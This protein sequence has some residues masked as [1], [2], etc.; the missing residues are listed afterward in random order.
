[1][2]LP[3]ASLTPMWI[4]RV[5]LN[6]SSSTR[7]DSVTPPTDALVPCDK[8]PTATAQ[9]GEV[10]YTCPDGWAKEGMVCKKTLKQ[11][12]YHKDRDFV[13]QTTGT[14]WCKI[15][16]ETWKWNNSDVRKKTRLQPRLARLIKKKWR[17]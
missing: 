5:E 12:R 4:V 6:V 17:V 8:V 11:C 1:M 9:I 14:F 15:F 2:K 3:T 13:R 16:G 7:Q 10:I